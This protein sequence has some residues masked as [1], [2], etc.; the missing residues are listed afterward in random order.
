MGALDAVAG[1]VA[2]GAT[3]TFRPSGSSMV[4]LILGRQQVVVAPVDPTRLTVG[5]IVLD[6]VAGTVY[7]HLVSSLDPPGKRVRISDNR[8]RVNGWTS[9]DRIFGSCLAV[10]GVPRPGAAVRAGLGQGWWCTGT[11]P[12]ST[13]AGRSRANPA[14]RP[15][16]D[17]ER[18]RAREWGRYSEPV[19]NSSRVR[20]WSRK[21][22][23]S[24]AAV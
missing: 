16:G 17:P 13:S 19:R 24:R 8:G 1:R 14:G 21:R 15:V 18:A 2:G 5:D 12:A 4:P 11:G 23:F 20:A 22:R 9:H 10:D 3:V 6:R 7:L